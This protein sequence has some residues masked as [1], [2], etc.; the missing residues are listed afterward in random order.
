MDTFKLLME[1]TLLAVAEMTFCQITNKS[2]LERLSAFFVCKFIRSYCN[3]TIFHYA[4]L[5]LDGMTHTKSISE[6]FT[7]GPAKVVLYD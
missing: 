6:I 4:C 7:F 2:F 5:V 3:S 1:N